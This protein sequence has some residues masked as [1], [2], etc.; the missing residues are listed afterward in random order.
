MQLPAENQWLLSTLLSYLKIVA[1]SANV[2]LMGNDNLAIVFAPS[3]LRKQ[4][5]TPQEEV[6]LLADS[7]AVFV[8]LLELFTSL[9]ILRPLAEEVKLLYG[10]SEVISYGM[11]TR[12]NTDVRRW[13]IFFLCD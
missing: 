9:T 13:F 7:R 10:D 4:D 3:V 8:D 2:N 12:I 5:A 11:L 1:A 6:T